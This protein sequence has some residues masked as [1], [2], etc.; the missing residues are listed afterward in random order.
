[1]TNST[2]TRRWVP[3]DNALRAAERHAE[4]S[5]E[6]RVAEYARGMALGAW[7]RHVAACALCS[8]RAEDAG[9]DLLCSEG[10]TIWRRLGRHAREVTEARAKQEADRDRRQLELF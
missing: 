8:G 2:E 4:A 9:P 7:R 5:A 10:K 1:M 6:L 3:V